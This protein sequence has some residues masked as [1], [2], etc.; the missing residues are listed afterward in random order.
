MA[1][2]KRIE[3]VEELMNK[4][5][6]K[7]KIGQMYQG[8]YEGSAQT[9]PEIDA[10]KT[11]ELI[12]DGRVGSILN[13][14][15][16]NTI[17]HL[18]L[19]AVNSKNKI[20]LLFCSDIIH[21][22][23][24]LLPINLA[25]SCSWNP[26]LIEEGS[27]MAAYEASHSGVHVTY[28]P[29]VNLSRDPRWGRVMESNGE[30]PYLSKE[31]TKSY[32]N[33]YQQHDLRGENSIAACIKH[34]A[35]YGA[36]IGGRDYD[37]CDMSEGELFNNYLPPY[38]EAIKCDVAMMMSSFNAFNGTPAVANKYLLDDVLR[39]KLGF[40]KVVIT[41]YASVEELKKHKVARDSKDCARLVLLAKNDIEM[42]TRNYLDSL[43]ELVN[44]KVV[45][46]DYIND[47]CRRVLNLKYELGLFTNPLKNIY[48]DFPKYWLK[49]ESLNIS[50]KVAD[51]SIVLLENDGT[52]PLKKEKVAFIGPFIKEKRVCGAWGGKCD[53]N[54]T[55]TI[56]EALDKRNKKYLY[57]K[58]SNIFDISFE[59]KDEAIKVAKESEVVVLSVGEEQW[60]SGEAHSRAH[61]D[62]PKAQDELIDEITSLGKKVVL[63]IFSGR[64]LVLTKYKKMYE[65]GKI[66]A[67]LFAWFLGTRSGDTIV[68]TL[69]GNN[70]PS[71]HLTMSFPYDVG[72]IPVYYNHLNSGRPI[73]DKNNT[74]YCLRYIDISMEPLYPF[75]YGL[76]YS[77]VKYGKIEL[78]DD[79][80]LDDSKITVSISLEN[81]SSIKTKEVV[82]MYIESMYS[83]V[84]RPV[85]ELRGFKKVSLKPRETK[86]VSFVINKDTLSYYLGAKLTRFYGKYR[87]Y[88]VSDSSKDEFVVIDYLKNTKK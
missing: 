58:G 85:K 1:K 5:T 77:N 22:C 9:G 78:S 80:L 54:D 83:S 19:A 35:G 10:S 8:N 48:P 20:P 67:I 15:D 2:E 12:K 59:L 74:E 39:K 41:D 29:M 68:D 34:F 6:L 55:V 60:M 87:I 38:K 36:A 28:S 31:L 75:G 88:L 72:Q 71:A 82:Q 57:A 37:A 62:I 63:L 27:K 49:E 73:F 70:N 61:L 53:Y 84:S 23:R 26:S 21:G 25:M 32:I 18:Q 3:F 30:D 44:S 76:S 42:A 33:G 51:E 16:N 81:D 46:E 66:N 7:E 52:L 79:V 24:T 11:M 69:Y 65:E 50:K 14:Y 56:S 4:M 43:E 40:K 13:L 45:S 86:K 17:K 47:A 64:P